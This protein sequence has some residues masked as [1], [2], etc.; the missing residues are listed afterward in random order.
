VKPDFKY[1][2]YGPDMNLLQGHAATL[3]FKVTIHMLRAT[4]RLNMV[5]VFVIFFVKSDFK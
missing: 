4:R 3:T 2:G 1:R 5:I